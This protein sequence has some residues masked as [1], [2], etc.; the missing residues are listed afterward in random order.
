GREV[1]QKLPEPPRLSLTSEARRKPR[2]QPLSRSRTRRRASSGPGARQA[3]TDAVAVPSIYKFARVKRALPPAPTAAP[4]SPPVGARC[5]RPHSP[6]ARSSRR[7]QLGEYL[8]RS[9]PDAEKTPSAPLL[10]L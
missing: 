6:G 7:R 4:V 3:A 2:P 5:R 9:S 1:T 10:N 8:R